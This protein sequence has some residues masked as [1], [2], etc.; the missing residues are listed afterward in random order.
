MTLAESKQV[1]N[2]V[3]A[4][5]RAIGDFTGDV[6]R[7]RTFKAEH[8]AAIAVAPRNA[9][10]TLKGYAR[11]PTILELQ[12]I[13]ALADAFAALATEHAEALATLRRVR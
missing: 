11:G 8:A 1:R 10:G 6:Q 12:Q 9:D 5:G 7:W 2:E 3:V 13:D 4:F